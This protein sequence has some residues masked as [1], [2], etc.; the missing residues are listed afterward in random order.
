MAETVIHRLETVE[1][2]DHHRETGAKHL[3]PVCDGRQTGQRVA[4]VVK[5]GQR[6]DDRKA[7]PILHGRAQ[8]VGCVFAAKQR[9][10]PQRKFSCGMSG[11]HRLI[12]AHVIGHGQIIGP[13][14]GMQQY[15]TCMPRG[16]PRP[17]FRHQPKAAAASPRSP[18]MTKMSGQSGPDV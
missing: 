12:R 18:S 17:Q 8:P 2:N 6:I 10:Q 9:P 11:L 13:R 15:D 7:Q 16:R 5:P 14:V 4:A 3:R 1:I